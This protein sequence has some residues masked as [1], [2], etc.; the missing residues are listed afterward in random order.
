MDEHVLGIHKDSEDL[1]QRLLE[2]EQPTPTNSIFSDHVFK[3]ACKRLQG[4]NEARIIKDLTPLIVPSA[5]TLATLGAE[6][7]DIVAES[8]NEGWN[9]CVPVTS[10]RPQP[11]YAVGFGK[12]G[13]SEEQLCKLQPFLGGVSDLSYF[14]AT[15]YMYFPFL[16]C[17]VK[18]GN[19]LEVADRQNAHS[20]SVAVKAVVELFKGVGREKELHRQILG[21]SFSHDH[22]SVR[23]WGHYPV[24]GDGENKT[25]Y[26]RYPIRKFDITERGGLEKW[27]AYTFT[28][29]IYDHWVTP[30]F[31]RICSAIDE[32][33]LPQDST[34]SLQALDQPSGMSQRL[35]KQGTAQGDLHADTNAITPDV[36][37]QT[38]ASRT[39]AKKQKKK[40]K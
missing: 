16:A 37:A 23:I 24:I 21:F 27:T 32:V 6:H 2:K 30:H 14:M 25:T 28:R 13:F 10:T 1:C 4:K 33:P 35:T 18:C 34:V 9:R 5:E 29:N 15:Y 38:T 22:G 36:S 19:G 20:M 26:W 3:T 11:D 31:E 17:E 12:A 7:L 39:K 8:V 40:K